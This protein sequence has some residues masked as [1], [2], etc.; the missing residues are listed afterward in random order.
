MGQ[1]NIT[2]ILN[3]AEKKCAKLFILFF[4]AFFILILTSSTFAADKNYSDLKNQA[5]ALYATE[6]YSEAF[7]ILD[8]FPLSEKDENIYLV[9][10]N[11][12]EENNDD[13]LAIANLNKALNKNYEFYKAYYNLGCI[14]AKKKSYVLAL[15]N[16]EISAK[17]KKDFAPTYFNLGCCF[18]KL[19]DYKSAKKNFIKALELDNT[20]KETYYNLAYCYKMLNKQSAAKRMLKAYDNI[21]S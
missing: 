20:S 3:N 9:L 21:K 6:N 5:F 17:Y 18:L 10:S 14:F 2:N 15:N 13:N 8:D 1:N 7:K 12:A 16:F 19:K 11:I 4:I